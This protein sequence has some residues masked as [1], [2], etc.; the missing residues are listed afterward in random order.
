MCRSRL[1]N[2]FGNL[3]LGVHANVCF[4]SHTKSINSSKAI[5]QSL[6]LA[7]KHEGSNA[8]AKPRIKKKA[9]SDANLATVGTH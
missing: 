6:V 5:L 7:A 8:K 1:A 3:L 2:H 9:K 4:L